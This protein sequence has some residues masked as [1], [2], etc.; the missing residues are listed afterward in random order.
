MRFATPLVLL[1]ILGTA[2]IGHADGAAPAPTPTPTTDPAAAP[3]TPSVDPNDVV[4]YGIDVRLREVFL[5][6]ALMNLFVDRAAGGA[7]SF[8]YGVDL[9]RRR[10]TLEL[11]LGAEFEHIALQEGVYINKGDDV[12]AGDTADYILSPE[13]AGSQFGWVTFEF[14]FINHAVINKYLAFRYGGGLGIGVLTGQIKRIDTACAPGSTNDN[15]EPGC[16]PQGYTSST[17]QPGQGTMSPDKPGETEPAAYDLPG[18]FPVVNAILG[19]QIRPTDHIVVNIEGG[20]RTL[21]FVG[22]SVGYFF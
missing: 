12:A 8:G 16:V 17:G 10:G 9:I 3:S 21:P 6:K 14:S 20:I 13:H 18:V 7:Q 19:L 22:T 1:S 2:S 4:R 15:A 11:Q 5:P